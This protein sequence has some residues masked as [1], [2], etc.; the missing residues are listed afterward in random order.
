VSRLLYQNVL[1]FTAS[2]FG[3][4]AAFSENQK[5]LN[6]NLDPLYENK[7]IQMNVIFYL[8]VFSENCRNHLHRSIASWPV[9]AA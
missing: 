1:P 3:F 4:A 7:F 6:P 2:I 5:G 8:F 9:L